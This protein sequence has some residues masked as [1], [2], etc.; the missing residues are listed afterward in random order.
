MGR[1]ICIFCETWESG[2]IESFL[3]GVLL[4]MDREGLAVDLVAERIGNSVFTRPLEEA[5]VRFVE[6]S[7]SLRR[8]G[9]NQRRFRALLASERY[10][11]VHLNIYQAASLVYARLARR[12]GVPVRI[13]HSHNTALR[14]SPLR[15]AKLGVHRLCRS[16]LTGEATHLWACSEA[17][18]RFLFAPRVLEDRGWRMVPNAIDTERFRYDE[19]V[20]ARLRRS[21]ELEGCFVVGHVGRLCYQKNQVFLMETLRALLPV[22]PQSRLLLVGEGEDRAMLEEKARDLGVRE[23]VI[24]YGVTDRPE[25]LYQA[26]DAFA[27]PSVFEGFGIAALEARAAGLPVLCSQGVPREAREGADAQTLPS[28]P[29]AWAEA[30]AAPSTERSAR[31]RESAVLPP[32]Y[33]LSHLAEAVENVY[34]GKQGE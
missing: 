21:L 17:A 1:R 9:E 14:R 6:L 3:S 22:R 10:D 19:E 11:L 2:G 23:K 4:G 24:F 27:F 7:G 26:M 8:F 25:E 18:A 34:R 29:E 13:A 5:G 28:R 16:L 31:E 12:A 30:L 33:R 15:W 20:R 32:V